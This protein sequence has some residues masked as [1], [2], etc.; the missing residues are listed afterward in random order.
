MAGNDHDL[1]EFANE[2]GVDI[3]RHLVKRSDSLGDRTLEEFVTAM[4]GATAVCLANVLEPI[5]KQ[6]PDRAAAADGYIAA[7]SRQARRFLE[8][9]VQDG[10]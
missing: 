10:P 9:L 8:P 1:M 7:C 6:S 3:F 2:A 5:V 4:A